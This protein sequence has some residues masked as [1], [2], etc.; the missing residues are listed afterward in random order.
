MTIVDI[1]QIVLSVL[2]LIATVA[3]SVIIYKFE[4]KNERLREKV[5]E[6]QKAKEIELT[7][8]NFII[9]N[10]NDIELLHSSHSD[11]NDFIILYLYI[12][13]P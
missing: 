9:D 7:A 12:F 11:N 5:L 13:S 4:R 6:K 10:Q 2:S 8:R 1:I 3:V